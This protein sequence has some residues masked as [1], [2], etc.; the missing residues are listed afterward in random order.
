MGEF[1][2]SGQ[3]TRAGFGDVLLA[4]VAPGGGVVF[5]AVGA[6][7]EEEEGVDGLHDGG[8]RDVCIGTY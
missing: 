3:I 8:G 7:S 6:E 2:A 1:E 4:Y 5:L